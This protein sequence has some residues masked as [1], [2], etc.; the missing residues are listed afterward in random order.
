MTTGVLQIILFLLAWFTN[1]SVNPNV[2]A[3]VTALDP[4]LKDFMNGK[5]I[6]VTALH[7]LILSY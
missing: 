7:V 4:E 2:I 3:F 6:R 1:E 5:V